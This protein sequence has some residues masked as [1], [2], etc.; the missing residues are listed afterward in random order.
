MR[1]A[2]NEGL[3]FSI[4]N[5]REVI[6]FA[7]IKYGREKL[8]QLTIRESEMKLMIQAEMHILIE[9]LIQANTLI[10]MD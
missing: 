10:L 5:K 7:I 3:Q 4:Q 9:R 2:L 6:S 1:S 8:I